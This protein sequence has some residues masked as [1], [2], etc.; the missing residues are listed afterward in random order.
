MGLRDFTIYDMI[1]R[2]AML[3]PEKDA[4]VFGDRRMS[5]GDYK[6]VCDRC[7]A[8]LVKAGRPSTNTLILTTI[9]NY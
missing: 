3:Y 4:V 9:R 7:A 1:C 5:H 8:G 6:I 2:N